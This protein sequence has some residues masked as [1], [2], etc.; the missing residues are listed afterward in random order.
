MT[1]NIV[2]NQAF[3]MHLL[4]SIKDEV[5]TAM[6]AKIFPGCVIGLIKPNANNGKDI[7]DVFE[8]IIL[9]YGST[10]YENNA[11]YVGKH[12]LYDIASIT[13]T[14]TAILALR[15]IDEGRISLETKVGSIL[16][17]SGRDTDLITVYHLLTFTVEFDLR[18]GIDVLRDMPA[19]KILDTIMSADLKEIPGAHH[20]YRNSTTLILGM[21]IEAVTGESLDS[22][23][24]KYIFAPFGMDNT[25]YFPKDS[26]VYQNIVPTEY[27]ENLRKR[28]ITGEVHDELAWKFFTERNQLTGVAGV[29]S[30]PVDLMSFSKAVLRGC[31]YEDYKLFP[32]GPQDEQ[33]F[34]TIMRKNQLVHLPGHRF[35]FGWDKFFPQYSH[36]SCFTKEAIVATGFTGCSITLHVEKKLGIVI[37]TNV[38]HPK[39][40]TDKAMKEFRQRIANLVVYCK[41]CD[42]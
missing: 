13:K 6:R 8:S 21:L 25:T 18:E 28:L 35:G 24:Y 23:M 37:C 34:S 32:N 16:P 1:E 10:A 14:F 22:L 39:R 9:S 19:D 7:D 30:T 2:E 41:H 15:L 4:S 12:S 5:E 26:K 20:Q 42:E 27:D 36:C 11:T 33:G 17:L 3:S 40:R 31:K 38:V 29:F